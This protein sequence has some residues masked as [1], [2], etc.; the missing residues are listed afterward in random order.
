MLADCVYSG[1]AISV[2]CN[3]AKIY[4]AA[5]ASFCGHTG[6]QYSTTRSLGAREKFGLGTRLGL[7]RSLKGDVSCVSAILRQCLNFH[8]S[9]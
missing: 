5:R 9:R 3:Q 6:I 4:A 2:V 1:A 7:V 8:R